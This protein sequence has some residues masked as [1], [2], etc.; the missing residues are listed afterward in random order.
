M[1]QKNNIP[2]KSWQA[3]IGAAQDALAVEF[4]ESLSFDHRLARHDILGSIAHATMLQ[5]VGILTATDLSE[6]KRGLS[7]ILADIQAKKFHFDIAQED[8]HMAIEAA[9]IKLVGEP[10]RK[11]HTARSRNDQVALDIRLWCREA[12]ALL[13]GKIS[14]LQRAFVKMAVEQGQHPVPSFTHLQRAQ[15]IVAGHEMLAWCEMLQRDKERLADCAKRVNI[16]PLGAGAVG[17]STLPIDRAKA[18]ALLKMPEITHNSLDSISDR[19]FLCELA[20]DLSMVAM[21]LSRW[22]E[23]WILYVTTEFGFMKIADAFTT[24]SSMMPQKRNPDMLEL[25]RGKT[26]GVYGQLVALLTIMKG[27]PL[28]YNRDMQED[29]RC[30][31]FAYDTVD[32]CLTMA[33]AIVLNTVLLPERIAERLDE[34]FADATVMAEYL[35]RK[36][37]P[38]RTAHHIVGSLVADCEKKGFAHL[39]DLDLSSMRE[40]SPLIDENIYRILGAS[41]VVENYK[42]HGAGGLPQLKAQLK[43]WNK[44]LDLH[45]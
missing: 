22:A 20:F 31:F 5:S 27:Q 18:A 29:K 12:I 38:F 26:G 39:G 21:H 15:P 45:A 10:G 2:K 40:K 35:V 3:R 7:S 34:G 30:I 43:R 19:D 17:G 16:S 24:G 32:A 11:L 14:D 28:A 36:G 42:S 8:I 25:I 41:K 13:S 6:I 33:A 44:L 37:V 4:V 1:P 9:L 23:Q